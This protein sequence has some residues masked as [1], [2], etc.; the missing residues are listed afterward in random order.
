M[1]MRK[2]LEESDLGM[3]EAKKIVEQLSSYVNNMGHNPEAFAEYVMREHRTLQQQMFRLMLVSIKKWAETKE[4]WYDLRNEDTVRI[5]K[6]LQLILDS[7]F[8]GG[9]VRFI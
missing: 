2:A 8:G 6:K 4:G 7:E 3:E 1:M 5:C 9:G